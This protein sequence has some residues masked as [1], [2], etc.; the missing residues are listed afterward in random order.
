MKLI[1]ADV[2]PNGEVSLPKPVRQLLRLRG[3]HALVGFLIEGNRVILTRARVIPDLTLSDEEIAFL[4]SLSR[5][6]AGKQSFRGPEPALQYL[7]SL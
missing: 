3:K 2:K 4:S 7:W 6:G 1:P 5:Q